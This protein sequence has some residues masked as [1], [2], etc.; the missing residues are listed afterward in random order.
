MLCNFLFFELFVLL[1]ENRQEKRFSSVFSSKLAKVI[2]GMVYIILFCDI[3]IIVLSK[4]AI[5]TNIICFIFKYGKNL[6]MQYQSM[7]QRPV[8]GIVGSP[9]VIQVI[10]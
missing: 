9:S 2:E 1:I 8:K 5:G 3:S 7:L 6:L 10:K 4:R